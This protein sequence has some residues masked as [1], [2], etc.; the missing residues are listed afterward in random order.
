MLVG[1]VLAAGASRRMGQPKQMLPLGQT[2]VLGQTLALATGA[3]PRVAVVLGAQ[4]EAIRTQVAL[5]G[6]EIVHNPDY[7]QGQATSLLAGLRAVAQW[8]EA[9]AALVLLGDQPTVHSE[10]IQAVIA[11]YQADPST[12]PATVV[13]RYGDR[14]GNPVLFARPAW[15]QLLAELHGDQGARHLLARGEP[16]PLVQVALPAAWW[17]PDID[18]WEDYQALIDR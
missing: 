9:E 7:A 4:A 13:P 3:L 14:L 15:P 8:P 6:A 1:I 5:Q 17:P 11:A 2:T 16:A 18:T 10:A 12:P